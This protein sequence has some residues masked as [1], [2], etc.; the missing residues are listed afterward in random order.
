MPIEFVMDFKK[1]Y[2]NTD[3]CRKCGLNVVPRLKL[4]S[5][6][7]HCKNLHKQGFKHVKCCPSCGVIWD[8]KWSKK[9]I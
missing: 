2:E 9:K 7:T 5:W 6:A 4:V 3:T 1:I 8:D